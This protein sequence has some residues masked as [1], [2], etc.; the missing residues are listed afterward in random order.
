M[1]SPKLGPFMHASLTAGLALWHHSILREEVVPT[2]HKKTRHLIQSSS[3]VVQ[4]SSPDELASLK[5]LAAGS[6]ASTMVRSPGLAPPYRWMDATPAW[7]ASA[8]ALTP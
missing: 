3:S 5:A 1:V 4:K 2:Y 7:K 8:Q 6:S